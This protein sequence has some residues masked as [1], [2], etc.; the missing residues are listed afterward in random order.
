MEQVAIGDKVY[1]AA[2]L[3]VG[4]TLPFWA[5]SVFTHLSPGLLGQDPKPVCNHGQDGSKVGQA[6]QDPEP[7][8][9][10]VP[11]VFTTISAIT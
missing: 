4:C 9:G 3:L 6:Q 8:Q 10:L 2:H 11:V 5:R 7:H 1:S